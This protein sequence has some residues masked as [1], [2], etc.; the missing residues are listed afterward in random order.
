MAKELVK[1]QNKHRSVPIADSKVHI[2]GYP[3]KLVLF[4]Q[5]ASPFY[6][7]RYYTDGKMLKRSTKT[8]SKRDA[9]QFAKD[10][11]DEINLKRTLNQDLVKGNSFPALSHALLNSMEAQ[12]ARKEL[13]NETYQNAQYRMEKH[14]LPFFGDREIRGNF[15]N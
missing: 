2:A 11:Y 5:A 4:R 10:F 3:T 8:D 9:I 1:L 7:V 6:W 15:M 13:T 12:V 14:I